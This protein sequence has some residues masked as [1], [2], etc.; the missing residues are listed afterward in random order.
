MLLPL[1]V[2]AQWGQNKTRFLNWTKEKNLNLII[3]DN[4][5][6]QGVLLAPLKKS[7]IKEKIIVVDENEQQIGIEV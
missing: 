7:N 4:Y 1:K 3:S 6:Q 2:A 5:A